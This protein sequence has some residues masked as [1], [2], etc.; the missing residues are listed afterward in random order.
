MKKKVIEFI[1]TKD[2]EFISNIGQGG[3]GKTVLLKDSIIDESFVCKKYSPYFE[4]HQDLFFQNFVD[5]IKILHKLFHNNIVRIFNYY[6]YPE[7][8]T[9]YILMEYVDGS[10]IKEY[11]KENPHYLNEIFIQT[12]IGF[13]ELEDKGILHRDIRADNLLVSKEG[14]VKI[15]DF[16]FGK[17]IKFDED[18][19]KSIT[20]NWLY[21]PPK[22]FEEKIYNF[23]TEV[24][25]VGKLF[26]EIIKENEIENFG[27]NHVLSEMVKFDYE[28]RISTF[29][30]IDRFI[31][32]RES[33]TLEFSKEDKKIYQDFAAGLISVFGTIEDQAIYRKEIE[34]IISGLEE[35]Y[36]NSILEDYVQKPVSV[37]QCFITGKYTY[38]NDR[39]ITVESLKKF[40]K[41]IKLA[42]V[43]KK[44]IVLN[45]L[46]Q[47]LDK[48]ERYEDYDDLPF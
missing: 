3:T 27:Y 38:Y 10:N 13:R 21:S 22:D 46:W 32:T 18:F 19:D 43:D 37:T 39:L 28:E 11:I 9:G 44:R 33:D 26:E 41:L 30:D 25:F 4:E 24:Y 1:R 34:K 47:R 16:G 31:L 7:R 45:N 29:S 35:V 40:L 14:I 15:I 17:K 20:L 12:I 42:S 5:E 48:V 8:K 6:L 36:K 23:R 2:F